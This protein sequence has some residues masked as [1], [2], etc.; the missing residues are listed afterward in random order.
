MVAHRADVRKEW[1]TPRRSADVV[2]RRMLDR[3][4]VGRPARTRF[5][6]SKT[7]ARDDDPFC[8]EDVP[9]ELIVAR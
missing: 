3:G 2:R 1:D 5:T 9:L 6:C 8:R 7:I 4:R